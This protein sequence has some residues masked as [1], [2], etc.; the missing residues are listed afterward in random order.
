VPPIIL[1]EES[2]SRFGRETEQTARKEE[3]EQTWQ[4]VK[5]WYDYVVE[6]K[7]FRSDQLFKVKQLCYFS[8]QSPFITT[9]SSNQWA[10]NCTPFKNYCISLAEFSIWRGFCMSGR[11]HLDPTTYVLV[12]TNAHDSPFPEFYGT[13]FS[14]HALHSLVSRFVFLEEPPLPLHKILIFTVARSEYPQMS[15]ET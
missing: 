14:L 9:H 7:R 12:C 1:Q 13:I 6:S 11:E 4:N 5:L 2:T 3:K 15:P 10:S 8:I